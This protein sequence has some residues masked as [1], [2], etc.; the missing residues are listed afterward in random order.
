MSA[1]RD[2][3]AGEYV[4]GTLNAAE[5]ETV[6]RARV[7]D[8]EL[9]RAIRDWERRLHPLTGAVPSLAPPPQTWAAVEAAIGH[10]A[11][12]MP[13]AEPGRVAH[14]SHAGPSGLGAASGGESGPHGNIRPLR[15]PVTDAA[16]ALRKRV[17]FWRLSTLGAGLALAASLAAL[18]VVGPWFRPGAPSHYVAVVNAGGELPA[19]IVNVDT[20]AGLVSVR[21][22][23]AAAPADKSLELWYIGAG[24]MPRSLG[25][26][27]TSGSIIR[28][29]TAGFAGF[30]PAEIV[31]AVTEEPPG[32]SPSGQPTGRVVYSGK[33]IPI[34][35]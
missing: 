5:R 15:R 2:I 14:A 12:L 28:A 18:V 8:A 23:A 19:L 29:S 20:G 34:P 31:F 3:L 35:E 25:T 33:L 1:A 7:G 24:Q 16:P 30:A 10:D 9:D 21:P 22:V 6:D 26:I 4:L 13:A 32:G 11:P 27:G 17:A